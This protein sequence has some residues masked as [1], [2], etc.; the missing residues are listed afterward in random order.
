MLNDPGLRES[1]GAR[2][3][4]LAEAERGA[5]SRA[6]RV[7]AECR[8]Q[9]VPKQMHAGPVRPFLWLLSK[10]WVAGGRVKRVMA[11][12]RSLA[13]PVIST[14]GLAMGGV[15]KTPMVRYLSAALRG[16]G[17]RTAVLTRGYRRQSRESVCLP[18]GAN[19]PVRI[20]GDEAQLLLSSSDVGIGADRWTVGRRMEE[21]FEPDVFL[22]DDGFQHAR[23]KREVDILLLDGLDPLAGDAPFP[24]GRMREP[25]EAIERADVIVITRAG[26]RR[27]DGLLR[28]LPQKPLFFADI[29][30]SRWVPERPS[31][32]RAA[33]FCGLANPATFFETVRGEDI[34]V[35]YER[36]FADHHRYTTEELQELCREARLRGA[37]ALVT[38]EKDFV[39]LPEGVESAV[40][41]LKLSYVEVRMRIRNEST[42]L[43]HIDLLLGVRSQS[44]RGTQS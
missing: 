23:L 20:T 12:E 30:V 17:Y 39:N 38:T 1:L 7:I 10:I 32:E 9:Y 29:E 31:L 40:A 4:A 36:T 34:N 3:K 24:L 28:R 44:A 22:L 35:V 25:E 42:F 21:Q 19:V 43:A 16:R 26:D 37:T 14:G 2:A 41:P 33:A 5:T 11:T 27:F 15:G 18:K 13:T 6:L 8:S